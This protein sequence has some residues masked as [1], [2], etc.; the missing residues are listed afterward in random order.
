MMIMMMEM[1]IMDIELY[2]K[3][4][5]FQTDKTYGFVT[6]PLYSNTEF[7]EFSSPPLLLL[8]HLRR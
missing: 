2:R 8:F 6:S 5:Y 1:K 4:I 7:R 3:S